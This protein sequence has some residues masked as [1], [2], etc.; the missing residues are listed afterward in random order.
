MDGNK[1]DRDEMPYRRC[2]GVMV[3]N[4]AGLVWAGR[5]IRSSDS[6]LDEAEPQLWQMPQGG[7]DE[8][9]TPAAAAMRELREETGMTSAAI[10]AE[11]RTWYPYDLPTHLIGRV[12]GGRYRGQMQKWFALR[13]DGAESEINILPVDHDAE[14]DLWRWAPV[15]ELSTLVVPFKR[16]VYDQVIG[17]FRHLATDGN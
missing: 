16:D 2:V 4:R 3:L 9:E 14:F 5:R 8:G 1:P 12:W 11:S 6:E 17:E 13:F 15:D 7:I 10:I